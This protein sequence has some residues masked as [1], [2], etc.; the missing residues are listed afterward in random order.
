MVLRVFKTTTTMK[1]LNWRG[2]QYFR[3]QWRGINSSKN[4]GLKQCTIISTPKG[5]ERSP[6]H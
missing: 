5:E 4:S 2:P 6:F 3:L 1:T